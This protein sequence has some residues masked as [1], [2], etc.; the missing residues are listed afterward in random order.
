M[1]KNNDDILITQPIPFVAYSIFACVISLAIIAYVIFGEYTQKQKVVGILVPD[2]GLIK[3][4]APVLATVETLLV[5]EGDFVEEGDILYTLNST[6]VSESQEHSRIEIRDRLLETR[7]SLQTDAARQKKINTEEQQRIQAEIKGIEIELE[8]IQEFQRIAD[9]QIDLAKDILSRY[10]KLTANGMHSVIQT[11]GKK[12]EMLTLLSQKQNFMRQYSALQRRIEALQAESV[13]A[14][15]RGENQMA[16]IGRSVKITESELLALESGRRI[17]VLSPA[18]GMVTGITKKPG[19]V[20][21]VIEPLMSLIPEG[22][23]LQ[24]EIYVPSNAIGFVDL[25]TEILLR[26]RA[27]PYQKFGQHSAKIQYISRA[28]VPSSELN[29]AITTSMGR[30][31]LVYR[32]TA[33]L[34]S[35]G[36]MAYGNLEPLQVGM[37]IDASILLD[38]RTLIEWLFEPLFSISGK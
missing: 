38:K 6:G 5:K 15:L 30:A 17:K 37:E 26:Y 33:N 31:A 28:A 25:D 34:P 7:K 21:D 35:Q 14:M 24:A 27:F 18:K 1:Q 16:A 8:E 23:K 20:S 11:Q 2:K 9:E 4:Y 29:S 3:V 12:V 36:V 13:T 22:A 19:Q 32:I 10:E